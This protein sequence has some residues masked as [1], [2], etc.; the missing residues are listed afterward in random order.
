MENWAIALFIFGAVTVGMLGQG[1]VSLLEHQRRTQTLDLIKAL[2]A[3]GKDPPQQLY[4]QLT[5]SNQPKAPW[6]E[7]VVFS[8][9]SFG[10]WLAFFYS[11]GGRRTAFLVVAA[12]LT[13]TAIGCIVLALTRPGARSLTRDDEQQ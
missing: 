11:E 7:V 8:A 9:L 10:F 4:D 13:V 1:W 12:S 2:L 6:T 3:A 5:Q